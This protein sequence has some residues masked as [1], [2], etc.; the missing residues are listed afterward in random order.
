MRSNTRCKECAKADAARSDRKRRKRKNDGY[1][2]QCGKVKLANA[3]KSCLSCMLKVSSERG[4]DHVP[5]I[6][7]S[8][9]WAK[10]LKEN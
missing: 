6:M 8:R 7:K 9:G 4:D 1:C 10:R 3:E 2:P 5:A